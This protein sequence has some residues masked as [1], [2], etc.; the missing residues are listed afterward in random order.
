MTTDLPDGTI[1]ILFTDIEGSTT[2]WERHGEAMRLAL[3]SHD[4]ILRAAVESAGGRVVKSTGDG[5]MAVFDG[6]SQAL[7]ATVAG[8]RALLADGWPSIAPEAVRVRMGLHTGDAEQR[9][10]DYYGAHVS[11]AA[12][13]MSLG[14]GGQILLSAAAA[15]LVAGTLDSGGALRDLGHQRLRGF[16]EPVQVYQLM[17]PGL[18]ADFPPLRSKTILTGNLPARVSSFIGRAREVAEV[19]AHLRDA[20]LLTLTGP[21]GTG[22]TRLSLHVAAGIQPDYEHGAWLVELAPVTDPA[23]VP[24]AVV[25]ALGLSTQSGEDKRQSLIDHLRDRE[26]LLVLDNC[27]HLIDAVADLAAG[28]IENCPRLTILA[29]S[30]EGLGVYGEVTYHLRTLSVPGGNGVT[31]AEVRQSEAAQ[32]F[33]ERA[34]AVEPR[35]TL[36]DANATAVAK[37]VRRLDGIP[38][39]IELAAARLAVFRPEQIA[40]RLDDRFRLLTGG[41][42]TAL[43]RQQTLRALIDWS[44]DLLD[45]DERT[46][47][48]RLSVFQGGWTFAAA[49]YMG[50]DIDALTILPQLVNK[51]LVIRAL[52]DDLP[53]DE[54]VYRPEPR[55][56]FLETIRQY[57]RDRL[58]ESGETVASR[59]RHFDYYL[60]LASG[61][62]RDRI[63]ME[64][65]LLRGGLLPERDNLRAAMEW[66]TDHYPDRALELSWGLLI[67]L[68]DQY[69]GPELLAGVARALQALDELPPAT[70]D[71]AAKRRL[72]RQRGAVA[73]GMIATWQG[74][75]HESMRILDIDEFIPE[76]R[77]DRTDPLLLPVALFVR[78]QAGFFIQDPR[79]EELLYEGLRAL[80]PFREKSLPRVH[81]ANALLLA[82]EFAFR[83]GD[84]ET[85]LLRLREAEEMLRDTW[86]S[87]WSG[88][89]LL[90]AQLAMVED[91]DEA[92]PQIEAGIAELRRLGNLRLTSMVASD[93]AHILRHAGRLSEAANIYRR[94][95]Q[96]WS[97]IGHR[98][99]VANQLE[100]LAFVDLEQGRPER[101]AT[102]LGAAER[103]REQSSQ[104]MLPD[105]RLEYDRELASLREMLPEEQLITLWSSGRALT[106]D[107]AV[108]LA[109]EEPAN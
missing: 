69:A 67:F 53:G 96:D 25:T 34:A 82:S 100:T 98:A 55:Y 46:L 47:F 11:R 6:A 65:V 83:K 31:A 76:L 106:A 18:R 7:Q 60:S 28:L 9:D 103:L 63:V 108:D 68:A 12:R 42:R 21:G 95:I 49:E 16:D 62:L 23:L 51:S 86:Y 4:A 66:G 99:A 72:A 29:S 41:S 57:A 43:P 75:L 88:Y 39:A 26:A 35:F 56:T 61:I 79:A 1:T 3:A 17:A 45:E 14:H 77:A 20:R 10:G 102:L 105:E 2:L 13:I 78:A 37:I 109:I 91:V 40:D 22:K 107:A 70:G 48:R 58:F 81:F 44:Y 32:L 92:R 59:H 36:T 38:L 64:G 8:Q 33:V 80:E 19:R 101:A 5:L 50:D 24:L 90:A 104:D 93:W 85:A 97:R 84:R 89:M 74:Q 54:A 30:R 94:T 52:E 27:E 87:Q 15:S 73:A 71:E